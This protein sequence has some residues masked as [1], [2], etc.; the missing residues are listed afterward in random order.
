MGN[1]KSR[2]YECVEYTYNC[3]IF[4]H[5]IRKTFTVW[6]GP[7]GA[8][9][10]SKKPTTS[11][12]AFFWSPTVM[13]IHQKLKTDIIMFRPIP[14]L[15]STRK[16]REKFLANMHTTRTC[17]ICASRNGAPRKHA[18][19]GTKSSVRAAQ[20]MMATVCMHAW[21][22]RR[23]QTPLTSAPTHLPALCSPSHWLR[24]SICMCIH[25]IVYII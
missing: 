9:A 11:K 25:I 3:K 10:L 24:F 7:G 23:R 14:S 17:A 15:M 5:T 21:C 6:R 2:Q 20:P 1:K 4:I 18:A 22:Q 8:W 19:C 16:F 12:S 13:F